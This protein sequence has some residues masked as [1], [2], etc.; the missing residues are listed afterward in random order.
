MVGIS[1]VYQE[2]NLCP[3]LSV[4]ENVLLGREPRRIGGIDWSTS[5]CKS[6]RKCSGIWMLTLMS[7]ET[8]DIYP[9]AIQQMVAIARA[10]EISAKVLILDEPTSSLTARETDNLFAVMR[11]LKQEGI[12]IIFITHFLDQVYEIS[13]RIT[14]LRNGKLVGTYETDTLPRG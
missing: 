8:L 2:V 12:G 3:N 4:A 14:V 9:V 10:L 6:R 1:T 5:Q 11:K 13:D 7:G